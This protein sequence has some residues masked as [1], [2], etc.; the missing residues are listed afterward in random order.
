MSCIFLLA[1]PDCIPSHPAPCPG[2]RLMWAASPG[3]LCSPDSDGICHQS[4][5]RGSD[6]KMKDCGEPRSWSSPPELCLS[7]DCIPLLKV[8]DISCCLTF[9]DSLS[10][11]WVLVNTPILT[12]GHKGDKSCFCYS[13]QDLL[14]LSLVC[15]THTLSSL[16]SSIIKPCSTSPFASSMRTSCQGPDLYRRCV[17]LGKVC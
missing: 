17:H 14:H 11:L 5:S 16:S 10:S 7:S 9:S 1:P 4:T 8:T 12:C 15:L 3:F 13:S 6:I 2:G